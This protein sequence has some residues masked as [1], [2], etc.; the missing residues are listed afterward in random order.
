VAG[1]ASGTKM[2]GDGGEP[3]ISSYR[4]V[5][6]RIVIVSV[7]VIFSCTMKFSYLPLHNEVQKKISSGT[8]SPG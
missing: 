3:L 7:P 5:S 2:G 6:S 4:V 1:R 8:G